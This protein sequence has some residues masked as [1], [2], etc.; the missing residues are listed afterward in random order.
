MRN[1]T[2]SWGHEDNTQDKY[3]RFM[4]DANP[5]FLI[6][7]TGKHLEYINK[8]FLNFLGYKEMEEFKKNHSCIDEF[9]TSI[10]GQPYSHHKHR[11]DR[12]VRHL[13]EKPGNDHIIYLQREHVSEEEA[14]TAHLVSC[15]AFPDFDK[16]VISFTD[17]TNIEKERCL[18]KQQAMTD[19]LTGIFNRNGFNHALSMEIKRAQRYGSPISLIM[20]D[21]DHFKKIND[22]FGHNVGDDILKKITKL[23]SENIRVYD[24]FARW[25]GEEFVI[26]TPHTDSKH[27]ALLAEKLR[28]LIATTNFAPVKKLTCSFGVTGLIKENCFAREMI[29]SADKALYEAKRGGRNRVC[30]V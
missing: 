21:I 15:T 24:I 5:T 12:W 13:I 10:N 17:I 30:I 7:T 28:D 6:T 9:I 22:T 2:S 8:T 18:L 20:L 11:K 1:K 16:Y 19:S 26:L 29:D 25:G 4:L 14:V 23:I 3:I 27:A